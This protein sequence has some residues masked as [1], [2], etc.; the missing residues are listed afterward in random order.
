MPPIRLEA[1]DL[2]KYDA[3]HRVLICRECQYAIQKSA[4][5]S[6]LLRHKIYR[7]ERYRLLSSI[8]E[9]DLFEPHNV[10]LPTSASPPIDGLPIISGYRCTV[11]GCG[12]LCASSKRMRRH[13]SE[14][15]GLSEVSIST[16]LACPVKIQTFFRGTKLRYFEVTPLQ[17]PGTAIAAPLAIINEPHGE[18]EEDEEDE[19]YQI[20]DEGNDEHTN[21]VDTA[22]PLPP[23]QRKPPTPK[24][25]PHSSSI[26]V[27]LEALTYF[28]HFTSTTSLTLPSTE[29][30]THYWHTDV[31]LQAL[32]LRWLMCGLLAISAYHLAVLA[33][34]TTM[35]RAHRERAAQFF[36]DFSIGFEEMKKREMDW[37]YDEDEEK[38]RKA[39][40]Q[41][42]S[43]LQ[44]A[45][46]AFG[47]LPGVEDTGRLT[48]PSQLQLIMTAIQGLILPNAVSRPSSAQSDC[49]N[50]QGDTFARAARI[51]KSEIAS[52]PSADNTTSALLNRLR[53]LPSRMTE[54]FGRPDNI[55]DV[56]ATLSAIA[57]LV[58]SYD[59][60]LVSN[61]A[62]GVWGCMAMWLTTISDHFK[63]MLTAYDPAALV[64][65]AHWVASL[66]KR[67]ED[68]GCWFLKGSA[69]KI[70][71]QIAEQLY[72]DDRALHRLV[73][74]LIA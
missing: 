57:A 68:C 4:L 47:I 74:I 3:E 70:L 29:R 10:P 41:I 17:A 53:E 30:P 8:A 69:N 48:V 15:H 35:E 7:K 67:A 9:L 20:Y 22:A 50:D 54:A 39:G 73:E 36:T 72:I 63:S 40:D 5:Q 13:W 23:S 38:V 2:F 59:T 51:L 18:D 55:R 46:W 45:N 56:L 21:D 65:L 1:R 64:V 33:D 24:T 43:I 14:I 27:N 19:S 49:D 37:M 32:Q 42:A 44:C 28:H 61:D 71:L 16:F 60:S 6:H 58:E 62:S 25:T 31:V 11:I 34:D 52:A 26:E 12:H 66:V